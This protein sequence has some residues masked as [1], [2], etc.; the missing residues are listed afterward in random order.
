MLLNDDRNW[1]TPAE[2]AK[3]NGFSA[4]AYKTPKIEPSVEAPATK[5]PPKRFSTLK[6]S[7]PAALDGRF[8]AANTR[9]ARL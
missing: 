2:K 8:E 5:L 3:L 1:Q 7:L 9:G 6:V 4:S